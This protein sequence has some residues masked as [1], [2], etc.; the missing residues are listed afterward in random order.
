MTTALRGLP[1]VKT[2]SGRLHEQRLSTF[3]TLLV[4][5][6]ALL[7]LLPL[8]LASHC[9]CRFI[10]VR[11]LR[12][13]FGA[14]VGPSMA[15]DHRS[16]PISNHSIRRVPTRVGV[17]SRLRPGAVGPS[18]FCY[19]NGHLTRNT[20]LCTRFGG[21]GKALTHAWFRVPNM[22]RSVRITQIE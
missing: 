17:Q 14:G 1:P 8:S 2:G 10:L 16:I 3:G 11:L 13:L 18:E 6:A 15:L 20:H 7:P 19:V 12:A 22:A 5:N 9:L 4:L 21:T